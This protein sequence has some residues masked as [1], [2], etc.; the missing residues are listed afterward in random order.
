[1]DSGARLTALEVVRRVRV[2]VFS[3]GDE[4]VEPGNPRPGAA[5]FDAN[6]HRQ[7]FG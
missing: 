6:L 5:L 3:T 2:A 4:I 7:L 1:M